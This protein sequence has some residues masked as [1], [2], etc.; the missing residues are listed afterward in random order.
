[1]LCY[2]ILLK[3]TRSR[4]FLFVAENC[5][6]ICDKSEKKNTELQKLQQAVLQPSLFSIYCLAL[7]INHKSSYLYMNIH[8]IFPI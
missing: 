3:P 5:I 6:N 2:K 8:G 4:N 7:P 1:M